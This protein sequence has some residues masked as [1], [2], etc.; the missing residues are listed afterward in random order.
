[1]LKVLIFICSLDFVCTIVSCLICSNDGV[2]G[3][4][5][6]HFFNIILLVCLLGGGAWWRVIWHSNGSSCCQ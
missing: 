6:V 3:I 2:Y 4:K 1:M 5:N